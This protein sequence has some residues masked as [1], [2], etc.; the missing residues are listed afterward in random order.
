VLDA[1]PGD[2][3]AA[4]LAGVRAAGAEFC[5]LPSER[6]CREAELRLICG[7]SY[8]E[9]TGARAV[10]WPCDP[11]DSAYDVLAGSDAVLAA[12]PPDGSPDW[13]RAEAV[14]EDW[15][16]PELA[17]DYLI[18]LALTCEQ[19]GD[20]SLARRVLER[21]GAV[22]QGGMGDPYL[23][24]LYANVAFALGEDEGAERMCR[25]LIG[26]GYGADNWVRLGCIY[27]R[28]GRWSE[29]LDAYGRGLEGIGLTDDAIEDD[30]LPLVC[31][32]DPDAFRAVLGQGECLMALGRDED[33]ARRLRQA[34]R[35]RA[36]SH[37]PF[38]AMGRL[39]CKRGRTADALAALDL[40]ARQ[41]RPAGDASVEAAFAEVRE[42]AGDPAGAFEA[43][44]AGLARR[45]DSEGLLEVAARLG[46]GLGRTEL[47][48]A[49]YERFL[50]HRPGHVKALRGLSLLYR[51][52]GRMRE[53]DDLGARAALFETA[54]EGTGR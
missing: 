52:L 36:N 32:T 2:L 35:L 42:R 6:M 33:A 8:A 50:D 41:R 30:A 21:A 23:V 39:L 22:E 12:P 20:Y 24:Q 17:P 37:R 10:R 3:H 43:S 44:L 46:T 48:V 27:Q 51:G 34:S 29:A 14:P 26:E 28:Q 19:E 38:V 13:L 4:Y 15:L 45:P 1:P 11:P 31:R 5:Y 9:L 49:A 53:A 40:A 7:L 16:P 25:R 54:A 18:C 47:L